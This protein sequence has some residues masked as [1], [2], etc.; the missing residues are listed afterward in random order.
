[1]A[2]GHSPRGT[3]WICQI[4]TDKSHDPNY[5]RPKQKRADA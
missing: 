4:L 2:V 1:V 5:P 3:Q